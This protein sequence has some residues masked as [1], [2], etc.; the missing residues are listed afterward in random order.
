M[1]SL[2]TSGIT[3]LIL[4][5]AFIIIAMGVSSVLTDSST[6]SVSE[7][8]IDQMTQE[9]IDEISTYIQ[10]RD[11][12]GKFYK[13]DDELKINKIALLISPLVTQDIRLSDLTIQIDDGNDISILTYNKNGTKINSGCI[14]EDSIWDNLN[15]QDFGLIVITDEDGSITEFDIINDHGDNAYLFFNLPDSLSMK[16]GDKLR[17]TLF[18]NIGINREII[19][20]APMPITRTINFS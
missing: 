14:F 15:G 13:I 12:L 18:P 8:D 11:R 16:K 17:V 4:M 9:T 19:L 6:G 20:E 10:I 7:E 2:R 5:I 1:G 3:V